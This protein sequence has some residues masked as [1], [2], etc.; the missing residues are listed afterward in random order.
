MSKIRWLT[1]VWAVIVIGWATDSWA[2]PPLPHTFYGTVK[3]AGT[4]VPNGTIVSAWIGGTQY[5]SATTSTYG[6][7][8]VYSL[9]VPADDPDTT[10]AKE[11]GINGD[12]IS[13]R[14]GSDTAS[15]TAA[16]S[17]G[18]NP[19]LNLTAFSQCTLTVNINPGGGG[20]VSENPAKSTYNFGET[21]QLTATVNAGYI[22]SSWSG[23]ASG[24]TNPV[25]ITMNGNTTVAANFTQNQYTLTLNISP[26]GAGSITKNP[27]KA[28][29]AQGEVVQLTATA[30]PGYTFKG[31]SGDLSASTHL[32]SVV[33]NGP[34]NVAVNFLSI[35][36]LPNQDEGWVLKISGA[37][38]GGAALQFGESTFSGHGI[39]FG[40]GMF[41]IEGAYSINGDDGTMVGNYTIYDL[42]SAV[43]ESGNFSGEVNRLTTAM[44][45][46]LN[47]VDSEPLFNM[48]GV[49]LLEEPVIPVDWNGKITGSPKGTFDLL[50]IEPYQTGGD[51]YSHVFKVSGA[52][53]V[54]SLGLIDMEGYFFF[55]DG[56]GKN[57]YG[58]YTLTGAMSE[59]GVLSGKMNPTSGKFKF[60]L[61]NDS[62]DKHTF[63]GKA[64]TLTP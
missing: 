39:S 38:N 31:W 48:S 9:N 2:V 25:T 33:M 21:V 61:A 8:S 11:G 53:S 4:N 26:S 30:N 37:D 29:Y 15:Q 47:R 13:F 62:G 57:A 23:G 55:T 14:V 22:F 60:S 45:M 6:A 32:F 51:I 16:F 50:K 1:I 27:D 63:S 42:D 49:R 43:L 17:S 5:A 46:R 12:V 34:K 36:P 44:T 56:K 40:L 3:K 7:D 19:N 35:Q 18:A 52:G 10:L 20:S 59:T 58:I 64:A 24:S 41:E 28:T 54:P